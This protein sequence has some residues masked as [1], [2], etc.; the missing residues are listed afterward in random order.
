[1]LA[2]NLSAAEAVRPGY[3]IYYRPQCKKDAPWLKAMD[4][5]WQELVGLVEVVVALFIVIV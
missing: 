2:V 4:F 1:M 5:H 3:D